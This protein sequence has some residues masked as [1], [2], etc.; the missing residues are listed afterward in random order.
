MK[1]S[2]FDFKLPPELIAQSPARPRDHARLLVYNRASK[3]IIDD[4][5]YNLDKYLVPQTTIVVNDSKV[6]KSRLRFGPIEILILETVN[7][8]TIRALV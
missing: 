4:Y 6:E 2:D 8:T 3:K 7:P 1:L 5:F